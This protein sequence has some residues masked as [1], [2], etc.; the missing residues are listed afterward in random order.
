MAS[1]IQDLLNY[2]DFSK[3][4]L[5]GTSFQA[6]CAQLLLSNMMMLTGIFYTVSA[7]SIAFNPIF[8]K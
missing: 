4:S 7:A 6:H 5:L 2:V 8:W 3:Q 1:T